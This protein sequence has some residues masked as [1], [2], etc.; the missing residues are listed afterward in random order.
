MTSAASRKLLDELPTKEAM[1]HT[2][3]GALGKNDQAAALTGAAYLDHALQ[4]L[5]AAKFRPLTKP[6]YQRMFA[7]A[8]NGILGTASAKIRLAYALRLINA[9]TYED[10][11]TI[12]NI[13]NAFAHTLH[14]VDF[15]SPAIVED[16][17]KLKTFKPGILT[18]LQETPKQRYFFTVVSIY[19]GLRGAIQNQQLAAALAA[20]ESASPPPSPDKSP[21]PARNRRR[22]EMRIRRKRQPPP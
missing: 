12:N 18:A 17:A 10:L 4:L 21:R 5:L 11:L 9:Q 8:T 15:R 16:C 1:Q 20:P 6:E 19:A 14:D 22:K 7:S 13:R 3:S 2:L